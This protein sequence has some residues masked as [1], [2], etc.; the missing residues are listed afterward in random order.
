[1][2]ENTSERERQTNLLVRAIAAWVFRQRDISPEQQTLCPRAWPF[3]ISLPNNW[4][5][6][7]WGECI[8][9]AAAKFGRGKP[10]ARSILCR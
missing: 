4:M 7:Q 9:T 6:E 1:M 2:D 3:Q 5:C 8:A 10:S